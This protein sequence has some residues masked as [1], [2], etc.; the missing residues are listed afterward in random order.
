MI[1]GLETRTWSSED[2]LELN[3]VCVEKVR[4]QEAEMEFT[5]LLT[6]KK[7]LSENVISSQTR[8]RAFRYET[9]SDI[10]AYTV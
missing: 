10:N 2:S 4:I 5:S 7:F 9:K 3:G 6:G 8:L 1:A